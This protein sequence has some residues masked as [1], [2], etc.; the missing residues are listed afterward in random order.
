VSATNSATFLLTVNPVNDMPTISSITNRIVSEDVATNIS[1]TIGDKETAAGVLMVSAS[2][3]NPTLVSAFSFAGTG[4][5]RTINILPATNQSGSANITVTVLDSQ[6]GS[7]SATFAFS[8]LPV[9]DLPTL[10]AIPDMAV[11]EDSPVQVVVLTG[12][13]SGA[14]NEIQPLAVTVLSSNAVLFANVAATYGS[15]DTTG[16]VEFLPVP[17]ANGAGIITVLVSDGISTN[18]RSFTVTLLPVNDPPMISRIANLE[19]DEDATAVVPVFVGDL[20]TSPGG[21]VVQVQSSNPELL[22]E[23][24]IAVEGTGTNRVLRLT[25]L[26]D[27]SAAS[28]VLTVTVVDGSNDVA[29]TTFELA[30]RAVNDAPTISGLSRLTVQ[31]DSV[32]N[33]VSFIVG[34]AESLPSSLLVSVSSAN[35]TL[36]PVGSLTL[37]SSGL[38]RTLSLTPSSNEFGT[39]TVSVI[40]REGADSGA[41]AVT[42]TFEVVVVPLNDPPTLNPIQSVVIP[43]GSPT[44]TINLSGI[45]MGAGNEEQMLTVSAISSDAGVI[46]NP[47]VTYTSPG[48]SG[49]LSFAPVAG[50]AG[51]I[52]MTVSV[53]ESGGILTGGSNQVTRSFAVT[54]SGP[55]P[56]LTVE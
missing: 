45:G 36:F 46:P 8:V 3:S 28:T 27:Q 7:N 2:S 42:N 47:L 52:L 23:T 44:Q 26:A 41:L 54:V 16:R 43:S 39:T 24:G 19:I 34:D 22:D 50:A 4:S 12:I 14:A 30:V 29:T 49:T 38:A 51:S 31:E 13:S 35:S 21:L 53:T 48:A 25:P 10:D 6:S 9:N 37:G 18:S 40:V 11:E 17:D 15:G 1:F 20:E 56:A 33:L 32:T 5:N 55:G